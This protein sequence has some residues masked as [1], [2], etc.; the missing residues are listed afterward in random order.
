M[1]AA[2][3]PGSIE[4]RDSWAAAGLTLALL[5][6]A[7]GSPLLIIVGL[8]PIT[9][10]LGTKRELVALAGSLTWLGTGLGGVVMGQVAERLGVRFTVIFGAAMIALGLA[11]SASGGLWTVLIGHAVLVGFLGN[12]AL[13]P[14]LIVYVSRWFDRRRGTALA[15]ISSGQYVA[16]MLWPSAFQFALERAGWRDT[17]LGFA[18]VII[19]V[20]PVLAMF[21]RRPP[22]AVSFVASEGGRRRSLFG[23]HPNVVLGLI[24]AA[25]FCCCIPMSIPQGH[26]VAF[27]SDI[28]ISAAH[29]ALMLSVLQGA[30]FVTRVGWGTLADRIGGLK[31]VFLCSSF[32][33]LTIAAFMA[34]RDESWLF[35]IAAVYGAGFSGI[36]PAYVVAIRELFPPQEASWRVPSILFV[37]MGGMAFG[38]WF[39]GALYDHFGYY[40]PAFAVGVL[41]NLANLSLVGFLVLCQRR[42]GGFRRALA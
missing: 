17:M 25:G 24:C 14:P 34:T 16:G 12:G 41:F 10:D 29:G 8:K 3:R 20:V 36:I 9:E 13:Y 19:L 26:L 27:C 15:L 32:Q 37:S 6:F 38:S 21:L 2:S 5:S 35:L 7:Y 18:I 1:A 33:A 31:T 11:V 4:S 28:G 22:V 42:A 40:G 39:A 30:A 23:M